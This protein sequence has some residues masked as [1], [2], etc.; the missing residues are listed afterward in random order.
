MRTG[1]FL[2][3]A[4]RTVYR[5]IDQIDYT[6]KVYVYNSGLSQ[7]M[8]ILSKQKL[9]EYGVNS[10]DIQII[11]VPEG[12]PEVNLVPGQKDGSDRGSNPN[13]KP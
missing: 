13:K 2:V 11:D 7:E 8:V 10:D 12:V 6:G 1:T 4:I 5:L 9:N 3:F